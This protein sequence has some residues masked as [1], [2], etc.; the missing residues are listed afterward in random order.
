MPD[1]ARENVINN[2]INAANRRYG[3]QLLRSLDRSPG[4]IMYPLG[5]VDFFALPDPYPYTS[6]V[7]AAKRDVFRAVARYDYD[8]Y[9]RSEAPNLNQ[10]VPRNQFI[11]RLIR[12]LRQTYGIQTLYYWV[13]P[14]LTGG[15]EQN[16][17]FP[18]TGIS[19][20]SYEVLAP[21]TNAQLAYNEFARRLADY[22]RNAVAVSQP[23]T[24]QSTMIS[25]PPTAP[26]SPAQF[27]PGFAPPGVGPLFPPWAPTGT[28][29]LPQ[30]RPS[31]APAATYAPPPASSSTTIGNGT[32]FTPASFLSAFEIADTRA[33]E[34][35]SN[36]IAGAFL[37]T[38]TSVDLSALKDAANLRM[39]FVPLGQECLISCFRK[40]LAGG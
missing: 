11:T 6:N 13:N 16:N 28:Y 31:P 8:T 1:P 2:A 3:V 21:G 30:Y 38:S 26:Q 36:A 35:G 25:G 29:P 23:S 20:V 39:P 19:H 12:E 32:S 15:I 40:G 27:P 14:N 37:L 7:P 34:L 18:G 33:R 4:V 5:T 10:G 9:V 22:D 24:T 17:G